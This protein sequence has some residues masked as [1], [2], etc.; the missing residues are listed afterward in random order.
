MSI[1]VSRV[2][3]LKLKAEIDGFT[4]VTGQV[5]EKTPPGGPSPGRLMVASLGLCAELYAAFYLK[6]HNIPDD[7]LT[8]EITETNERFP[9][10]ASA[11]DV[12]V[13][14]KAKLTEEQ[15]KAMLD[16][17]MHCYVGNTLKGSPAVN[18]SLAVE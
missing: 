3:G 6:K 17:V 8:V 9:S 14:V 5:N 10:R 15:R 16:N 13:T 2:E 7:G 4:I 18:Y 1:K 12:R 11:F